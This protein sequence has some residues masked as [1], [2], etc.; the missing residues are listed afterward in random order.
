MSCLAIVGPN[1][2]E[3]QACESEDDEVIDGLDVLEGDRGYEGDDEIESPVNGGAESY[4]FSAGGHWE[5]FGG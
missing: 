4:A 2:K 1:D 3:G 5:D